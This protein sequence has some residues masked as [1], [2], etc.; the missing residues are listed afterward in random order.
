MPNITAPALSF[1][2][3]SFPGAYA[4]SPAGVLGE[5]LI[6][7]ILGKY[8]TLVKSQK[9]FYTSAIITAPVIFSTAGQL[10]PML[11]NK[12]GSGL[13]A[14]I[15]AVSVGSPTVATTVAGAIGWASGN[16]STAPTSPTSIV[17]NNAYAGGGPSQMGA[18]NSAGTVVVLPAPIFLPLIGVNTGAITT[19]V[20]N[21]SWC[22]V[23]GALIVGP[24]NVGYVCGS[25]TLTAGVFTIGLLW[26][27]LPA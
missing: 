13:D 12:P 11:W 1:P 3:K 8:A 5:L 4:G 2:A 26:A 21:S 18:V 17:S 7:E 10:G 6:S 16:Q 24:G 27:E 14:H 15:L 25:A 23:G 22:D 19:G 9:V 20:L